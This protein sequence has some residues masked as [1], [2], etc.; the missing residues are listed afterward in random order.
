MTA[1][2]HTRAPRTPCAHPGCPY[3]SRDLFCPLHHLSETPERNPK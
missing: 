2:R 3:L 1:T